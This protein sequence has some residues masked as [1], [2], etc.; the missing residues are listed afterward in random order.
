M[1][2]SREIT[3]DRLQLGVL[4]F[5]LAQPFHLRWRQPGV[6]LSPAVECRIRYAGLPTNLRDSSAILRL[7]QNEGDLRSALRR[8]ST[9]S[10]NSPRSS[11]RSII[12]KFQFRMVE[13][14]GSRSFGL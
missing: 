4:F 1:A 7:L 3:D 14:K 13:F 10:W 12:G 6:F 5:E 11:T 9:S 8:T 2:L